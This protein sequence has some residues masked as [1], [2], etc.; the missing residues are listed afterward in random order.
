MAVPGDERFKRSDK[1][2][3]GIV[4]NLRPSKNEKIARFVLDKTKLHQLRPIK[5]KLDLQNVRDAA[6]SEQNL[7]IIS[8]RRL[9]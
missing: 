9:N 7:C 6:Q 2:E 3:F 1:I 5:N 8:R 4:E